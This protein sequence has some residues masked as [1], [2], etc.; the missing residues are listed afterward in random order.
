ME[1]RR[2]SLWLVTLALAGCG[3]AVGVGTG[4]NANGGGS[5]GEAETTTSATPAD[6][7]SGEPATTTA[8]ASGTESSTSTGDVPV[9]PDEVLQGC[10]ADR[11][12]R[13][14]VSDPPVHVISID[15]PGL[16]EFDVQWSLPGE[17]VLVLSSLE[18]TRWRVTL[19]GEGSLS[20]IV[21]NGR[22]DFTVDAPADVEVQ[23]LDEPDE[24]LWVTDYPSIGGERMRQR[25]E[26]LLGMPVTG[27]DMC[28][29]D[30]TAAVLTPHN[31]LGEAEPPPAEGCETL[32]NGDF[33]TFSLMLVGR[34][35]VLDPESGEYCTVNQNE[36]Y[37]SE[38]GRGW[39]VTE[40]LRGYV[41]SRSPTADHDTVA[42]VDL[43]TGF[44]RWSDEPC[45]RVYT[46]SGGRVLVYAEQRVR[47]HQDFD[48]VLA[49]NPSVDVEIGDTDALAGDFGTMYQRAGSDIVHRWDL[50]TGAYVGSIE[51]GPFGTH[52]AF[53]AMDGLL[54][55]RD[56]EGLL[57]RFDSKSGAPLGSVDAGTSWPGALSCVNR[58]PI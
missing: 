32:L 29:D 30:A 13:G 49:Q 45:Q 52:D 28:R 24:Y 15:E 48:D 36:R 4:G 14:G 39:G 33:C 9:G 47:I 43:E 21:V 53:A 51:V 35:G 8:D 26:S 40:A 27:M 25:I 22:E 55:S 7:T 18:P 23:Q 16:L 5:S 38:L 34:Y 58:P 37:F 12:R 54:L 31:A 56:S 19:Q 46:S 10:E 6:T 20:R 3:P 11:F 44:V 2:G 50:E 41:C 42:E 17:G 1:G 57:Q